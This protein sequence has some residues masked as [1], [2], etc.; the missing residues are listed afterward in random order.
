MPKRSLSILALCLMAAV[1]ASG[2]VEAAASLDPEPVEIQIPRVEAEVNIDGNLNEA[3]WA[4]ARRV[5]IPRALLEP[6]LATAN[7]VSGEARMFWNEK[8]LY[9][10][11]KVNDRKLMLAKEDDSLREYDSVQLWFDR[12]WIQVG[13]ASGGGSRLS[14]TN[15][16][17]YVPFIDTWP[18]A[19]AHRISNGYIAEVFVPNRVAAAMFGQDLKAGDK[20]RLAFAINNKYQTDTAGYVRNSF[21]DRFGFNT[22]DS[23]AIATL[24]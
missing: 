12:L 17:K 8:G 5:V 7:D 3:A 18:E 9:V 23:M 10:G 13:L 20:I 16:G 6:S 4:Q 19:A 15:L 11:F 24:Q 2:G 14:V 22:R 1:L 21:P